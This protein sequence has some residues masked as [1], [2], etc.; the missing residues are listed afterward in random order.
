MQLEH[1]VYIVFELHGPH[2]LGDGTT[3]GCSSIECACTG[4]ESAS[5]V[6]SVQEDIQ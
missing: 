3:H 6:T 2:V 4:V 1:T 5:T